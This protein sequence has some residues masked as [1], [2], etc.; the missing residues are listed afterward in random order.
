ML[1]PKVW[2]HACLT[3]PMWVHCLN[4]IHFSHQILFIP[5]VLLSLIRG[6]PCPSILPY[7]L[8]KQELN[9]YGPTRLNASPLLK[10][11]SKREGI[12]KN[13]K[14]TN[15][16]KKRPYLASEK[17]RSQAKGRTGGIKEDSIKTIRW[18]TF[19]FFNPTTHALISSWPISHST[20]ILPDIS[21]ASV[22]SLIP[23]SIYNWNNEW[24]KDRTISIEERMFHAHNHD[25]CLSNRWSYQK[26]KEMEEIIAI[27][28]ICTKITFIVEFL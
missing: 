23:F 27:P 4:Q 11:N 14:Q 8:F 16:N 26:R 17:S 28:I 19:W 1:P 10:K 24:V 18:K 21:L 12:N 25:Q 20:N 22:S 15:S 7:Y 2:A 3:V 9:F 13:Y 6:P 5:S